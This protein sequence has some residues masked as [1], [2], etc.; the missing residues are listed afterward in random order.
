M[1]LSI[2][3]R[4]NANVL[5]RDFPDFVGMDVVLSILDCRRMDKQCFSVFEA[6]KCKPCSGSKVKT[7][8][9]S[10]TGCVPIKG[11]SLNEGT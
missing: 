2:N 4:A 5:T 8:C 1:P 9:K 7:T 11:K 10:R 6:P 3:I